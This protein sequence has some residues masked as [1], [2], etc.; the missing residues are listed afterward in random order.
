MAFTVLSESGQPLETWKAM[1]DTNQDAQSNTEAFAFNGETEYTNADGTGEHIF[2]VAYTDYAVS[3]GSYSLVLRIMG[4]D[5]DGNQVEGIFVA[6]LA[7]Q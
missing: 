7:V 1:I 4:M 2:T 5:V 3:G 6:T